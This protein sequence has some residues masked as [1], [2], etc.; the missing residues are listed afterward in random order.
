MRGRSFLKAGIWL[1]SGMMLGRLLG[2][3]REM[4]L[5]THYGTGALADF[6]VL[7]MLLPDFVA[8]ALIGG[9]ASGVLIPAFAARSEEGQRRLLWQA[10]FGSLLVSL[11]ALLVLALAAII[12][13]D[14]ANL[15]AW[16][17]ALLALPL[18]LVNAVWSAYLQYL[19]RLAAPAY[20]NVTYNLALMAILISLAPSAF[21]VGA[22]IVLAALVR[23]ASHAIA[24]ARAGS[25]RPRLA[26]ASPEWDRPMLIS[27][28]SATGTG[29]LTMLPHYAPYAVLGAASGVALFNYGFKLAWLPAMFGY[30]A[31]TMMVLPLLARRWQA[32]REAFTTDA[33]MLHAGFAIASLALT[34]CMFGASD[35]LVALVY[36]RG[37][38]TAEDQASVAACV[39]RGVWL[40]VPMLLSYSW[41]Q[42]C[43]AQGSTRVPLHVSILQCTIIW[44]LC[45]VGVWLLGVEGPFHA[46]GLMY[47]AAIIFY[48]RRMR[49][50]NLCIPAVP[51]LLIS[52][53]LMV[54]VF[55]AAH[56]VLAA[57]T[58]SPLATIALYGLLGVSLIVI[59]VLSA[60]NLRQ[61]TLACFR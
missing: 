61:W 27:Y 33:G 57:F 14:A 19:R 13:M 47:L 53:S 4:T 45:A 12:F 38:M 20:A 42:I 44:P 18:S 23:L 52:F 11:A 48:H 46:L 30:M 43:F 50:E 36:G 26:L 8:A 1:A 16:W 21:A 24:L 37:A 60:K 2:F 55:A 25:G 51:P 35:E 10:S 39:A 59:G 56:S 58:L 29:L 54:G 32:S 15:P 5:A 40:T 34:L 17:L 49:R 9:A 28:L 31:A 7:L 3:L 6:A 22:G 41:Q